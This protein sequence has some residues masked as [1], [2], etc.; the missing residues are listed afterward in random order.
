MRHLLSGELPVVGGRTRSR[1]AFTLIELLVSIGIIAVLLAILTPALM[2]ARA[3]ARNT[4]CLSNL[5][6]IAIGWASWFA[7]HTFFPTQRGRDS[8]GR[9]VYSHHWFDW[10]GIH[11]QNVQGSHVRPWRPMNQY[12][13]SDDIEKARNN[14]FLCPS[15]DG[16]K[17]SGE[18]ANQSLYDNQEDWYG[19]GSD[20]W[21]VSHTTFARYGTSYRANDW[22]WAPVG[23]SLGYVNPADRNYEIK[24]R[25]MPEWVR[26]P[27]HFIVVGDLAAFQMIRSDMESRRRFWGIQYSWWH[28][29]E[30]CNLAFLDGSARQVESN[31]GDAVGHDWMFWFDED[32]HRPR[33][34]VFVRSGLGT[35]TDRLP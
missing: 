19:H 5:S 17:W 30:R 10:G 23:R 2:S 22:I 3:A 25:N 24:A 9:V 34:F 7:D 4:S 31:P 28:A 16:W 32:L 13:G 15:D 14:V 27:S 8:Q 1:V 33:S 29:E 6:Q 21:D 20:A 35:P 12:I 18:D 11:H 26:R